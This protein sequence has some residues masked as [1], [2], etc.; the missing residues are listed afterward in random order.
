MKNLTEK[1]HAIAFMDGSTFYV[2]MAITALADNQAD[3]VNIPYEGTKQKNLRKKMLLWA[4]KLRGIDISVL[5][6]NGE[7]CASIIV[8][9]GEVDL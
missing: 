7:L 6:E 9:G 5:C 4:A 1:E 3:S 2:I 8:D